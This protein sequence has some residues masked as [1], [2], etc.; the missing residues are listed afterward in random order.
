MLEIIHKV[1]TYDTHKSSDKPN[2]I[3]AT[4]LLSPLYKIKKILTGSSQSQS[5]IDVKFKR[6]SAIGTAFHAHAAEALGDDPDFVTEKYL[7]REI[8]VDG[9]T[10][11]ISGSF[12]G[13]VRV[14]DAWALFDWKTA[15]GKERGQEALA[16]DA[17]QM[18]IY[19]WLING[20]YDVQDTAFTLFISQSNNATDSYSIVLKS[21]D[22][23]S[24]WLEEIIWSALNQTECDCHS[25]TK[26]NSCTYCSITDCKERKK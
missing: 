15:Y 26:Y 19:R 23:I 2:S 6:S 11:T 4:Q 8:T 17:M 18:S 10:Y 25:A 9:V 7:E 13:L 3:S 12:D 22:Y 1:L 16:K 14:N 21:E 20:R 5:M 24:N